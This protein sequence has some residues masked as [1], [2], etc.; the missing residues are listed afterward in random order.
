MRATGALDFRAHEFI[1]SIVSPILKESFAILRPPANIPGVLPHVLKEN[2]EWLYL[3]TEEIYPGALED[4]LRSLLSTC[5]TPTKRSLAYWGINKG[6]R[7]TD[8]KGGC[9][10][11]LHENAKLNSTMLYLICI[12]LSR[13]NISPWGRG[14]GG[15]RTRS[16][17]ES[18][19]FPERFQSDE[20]C[21]ARVKTPTSSFRR[22]NG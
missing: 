3:Q 12:S 17:S 15:K 22:V 21:M 4:Q 7:R 13:F 11:S 18:G 16:V 1:I 5:V 6:V 10:T 20:M 9:A 14:K 8:D 2:I 19:H